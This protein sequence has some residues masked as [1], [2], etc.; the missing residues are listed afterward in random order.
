MSLSQKVGVQVA[1]TLLLPFLCMTVYLITVGRNGNSP[2][3]DWVAFGASVSLGL[4]VLMGLPLTR[5]KKA[6]TALVY[7][8]VEGT[9]LGVYAIGFVCGAYGRCM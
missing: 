5:W 8:L 3:G 6:L 1:G 7:T 4:A 9:A 2:S